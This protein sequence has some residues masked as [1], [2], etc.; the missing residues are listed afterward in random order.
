MTTLDERLL[1]PRDTGIWDGDNFNR[2]AEAQ[3]FGHFLALLAKD[4]KEEGRPGAYSIA[5]HAAWG[6]GKSWFLERLAEML[7][8]TH[9]VAFVNAWLD[10]TIDDPFMSLTAAIDRALKPFARTQKQKALMQ[11]VRGTAK[12]VCIAAVKGMATKA[13][14]TFMDHD[15]AS[16]MVRIVGGGGGVA[17]DKFAEQFAQDEATYQHRLE[18][19]A[20]LK[21]TLA[22]AIENITGPTRSTAA[23]KRHPPLYI[24][25]DELDRCRPPYAI[26][27][28]ETV[29]HLLDVPGII[30]IY[31]MERSQ[32]AAAVRGQYGA[33]FEGEHYLRRFI[34]R[35]V[36]L[37]RPDITR[38]VSELLRIARLTLHRFSTP[39]GVDG[40]PNHDE[41]I[42]TFIGHWLDYAEAIEP[43]DYVA[44]IDNLKR[45]ARNWTSPAP[46]ELGLLIPMLINQY[47]GKLAPQFFDQI[48]GKQI[49]L[50]PQVII[51]NEP[52]HI[53]DVFTMYRTNI[54]I[55][56]HKSDS[57]FSP[58][59]IIRRRIRSGWH[60]EEK[61]AMQKG[62][63][64][65]ADRSP[66]TRYA[67]LLEQIAPYL[68][69]ADALDNSPPT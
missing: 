64:F 5:V 46:I 61:N 50:S 25:I 19:I 33:T 51:E 47:L 69:I 16:D 23:A 53:T 14:A 60:K 15:N 29:K 56:L 42:A 43:R 4:I 67:N 21:A 9:P 31:G 65:H 2:A 32:L 8:R 1:N 12:A 27:M 22:D 7:A 26:K 45:F 68:H 36:R 17:I 3:E 48:Q 57:Q 39:H 44:I 30:F 13:A 24:F 66:L 37:R 58:E 63:T 10:D 38:H 59:A 18:A 6:H 49:T 55:Q 40:A 20:R 62:M 54:D 41:R 34:N 28:L 11:R 52:V 35:E